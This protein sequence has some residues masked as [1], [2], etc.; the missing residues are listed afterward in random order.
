MSSLL[1]LFK[2]PYLTVK[3]VTHIPCTH[4]SKHA[5]QCRTGH[6]TSELTRRQLTGR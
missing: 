1:E 6:Q 4:Y 2:L 5:H 3:L